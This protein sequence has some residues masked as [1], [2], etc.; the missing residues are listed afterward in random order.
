MSS[1]QWF[2]VM[3]D[4]EDWSQS[5]RRLYI[6][7][8]L[9]YG[10]ETWGLWL[11]TCKHNI[12]RHVGSQIRMPKGLYYLDLDSEVAILE[13]KKDLI[14]SPVA[15]HIF[16]LTDL[17]KFNT[18]GICWHNIVDRSKC[19]VAK[20]EDGRWMGIDQHW[21]QFSVRECKNCDGSARCGPSLFRHFLYQNDSSLSQTPRTGV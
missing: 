8:T 18:D 11:H 1:E 5:N 6:L 14:A 12:N 20:T 16:P 2:F 4:T 13:T 17:L 19:Q 15:H 10:T 3:S 7:Y 21:I 9:K